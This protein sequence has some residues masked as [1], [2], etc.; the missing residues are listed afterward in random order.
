MTPHMLY[1]CLHLHMHIGYMQPRPHHAS[2]SV[3]SF[4]VPSGMHLISLADQI[5]QS[6]QSKFR[7]LACQQDGVDKY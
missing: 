6:L 3:S 2:T 7:A 1:A 4:A 5:M